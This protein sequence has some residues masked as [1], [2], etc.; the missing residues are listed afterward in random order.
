VADFEQPPGADPLGRFHPGEHRD[1]PGLAG[2]LLVQQRPLVAAAVL[3]VDQQPVEAGHRAR[4][5]GERRAETEER[6]A[7]RV[8]GRQSLP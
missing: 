4:L 6:P 7:H 3:Q 1:P 5:G 2:E 8:A